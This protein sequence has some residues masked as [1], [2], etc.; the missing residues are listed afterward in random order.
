VEIAEKVAAVKREYGFPRDCYTN[1]AKNTAKHLRKIVS[2]WAEAG[3][4]TN[5]LLSLQSVDPGTLSAIRRT[6]IKVE[7]YNELAEEFRKARL[8]LFV[9][10]M[11]G[12]PGSTSDSFHADLQDCIDREVVAKI[13]P[14]TLLPNSPM[15]D[16][17]YREEHKIE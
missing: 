1:F 14:T 4:L 2:I 10:L 11:V 7:K 6:N 16:P 15:N 13:H 9:D 17:A 8:P 5:G 12:L 3:I